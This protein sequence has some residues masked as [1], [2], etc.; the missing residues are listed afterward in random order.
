MEESESMTGAEVRPAG[1]DWLLIVR[2]MLAFLVGAVFVYAGILKARDPVQFATEINN[3]R[4]IPWSIGVRMAFYLP[5]LEV[6]CGLALIFHRL[7]AGA[8]ALTTGLMVVFIAA[9]VWARLQ[10]IDLA[11]GCFGSAGANLTPAWH[12]AIDTG[13]LAALLYLWLRG[14]GRRPRS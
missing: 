14:P 11:C 10:G 7:F 8:L 3:Y 5:W 2:R 12:L 1:R 9:T 6:L 4:L 13:L